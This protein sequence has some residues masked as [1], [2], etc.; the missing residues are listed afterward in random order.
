MNQTF[1]SMIHS[2]LELGMKQYERSYPHTAIILIEPDHRDV[3]FYT[4]NTFSYRQRRELAEHAY[5]QTRLMLRTRYT[6]LMG[7]LRPHGM[8]LNRAVLDDTARTLLP[9]T[10]IERASASRL[11]AAISRLQD[12][13]DDLQHA[14]ASGAVELSAGR[15]H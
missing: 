3:E 1:R 9:P 6:T 10:H 15:A 4:A 2:R 7:Q 14:I 5:Q 13:V 12:S 8:G 11:N